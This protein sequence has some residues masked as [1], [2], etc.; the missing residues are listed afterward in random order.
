MTIAEDLADRICHTTIGADSETI[1]EALKL[2]VGGLALLA[3]DALE[4][5]NPAVS[6]RIEEA[7]RAAR[8][9]ITTIQREIAEAVKA[10]ER[11]RSH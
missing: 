10:E 6:A 9:A 7:A 5:D 8:A 2:A 11:T 3:V 4:N 1:F